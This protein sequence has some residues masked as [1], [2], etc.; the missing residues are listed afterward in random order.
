M[1]ITLRRLDR[2]ELLFNLCEGRLLRPSL[3]AIPRGRLF[4]SVASC[5]TIVTTF[6]SL[7]AGRTIEAFRLLATIPNSPELNAPASIFFPIS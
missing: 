3:A 2:F 4:G 1:K 5:R 7:T 6:R